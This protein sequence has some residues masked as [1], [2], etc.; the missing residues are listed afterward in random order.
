MMKVVF[1]FKS[2]AFPFKNAF[3]RCFVLERSRE[4]WALKLSSKA[5]GTS[6]DIIAKPFP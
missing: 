1:L 6:L 5:K 2:L 3:E 4:A